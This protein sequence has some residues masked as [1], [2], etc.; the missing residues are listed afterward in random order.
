MKALLQ[1]LLKFPETGRICRIV[2]ADTVYVVLSE[3]GKD[4][5]HYSPPFKMVRTLLE[6]EIDG[7]LVEVL[8]NDPYEVEPVCLAD[9]DDMS[10]EQRAKEEKLDQRCGHA[11][12][13]VTWILTEV[14]I[15]IG[16]KKVW[17]QVTVAAA[18]RSKLMS[19]GGAA[20]HNVTTVRRWLNIYWR[21]GCTK[22]GLRADYRNIGRTKP[23]STAKKVGRK[24]LP[25]REGCKNTENDVTRMKKFIISCRG[26]NL[27]AK[28]QHNLYLMEFHRDGIDGFELD[29]TP[30]I[31]TQ[32][33]DKCP[34]LPAFIYYRYKDMDYVAESIAE[35]GETKHKVDHRPKPGSYKASV[36]APLE[37]VEIDFTVGSKWLV[38][39][40]NRKQIL[41]KPVH[42]VAY[43]VYSSA[44]LGLVGTWERA[45]E[46]TLRLLLENVM[47]DKVAFCARYGKVIKE[48]DWPMRYIPLHCVFDRGSESKW[49]IGDEFPD[50]FGFS[51]ENVATGDPGQKPSVESHFAKME[52][53]S[54]SRPGWEPRYWERGDDDAKA[55]AGL[56]LDAEMKILLEDVLHHNNSALPS[57][58]IDPDARAAGCRTPT[59]V[60]LFGMKAKA[61]KLK[62][63]RQ[64]TLRW[65][66]APP[67]K[68]MLTGDAIRYRNIEYTAPELEQWLTKVKKSHRDYIQIR[69]NPHL[70]DEIYYRPDPK[71]QKD[72]II[73]CE[74]TELFKHFKG[75]SFAEVAALQKLEKEETAMLYQKQRNKDLAHSTRTKAIVAQET[76]LTREARKADGHSP[77]DYLDNN[78]RQHRSDEALERSHESYDG[79]GLPAEN[80]ENV[81]QGEFIQ[82]KSVAA[83]SISVTPTEPG[84][85]KSK[86]GSLKRFHKLRKK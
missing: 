29:G 83:N 71:R 64:D 44:V 38:A 49:S 74:L 46:M 6:S 32:N 37:R 66:I 4:R 56:T 54:K 28:E 52:R 58:F 12:A 36:R 39:R 62:M 67:E 65:R 16:D 5:A 55:E 77:K 42:G 25:G 35:H 79:I 20:H 2:A 31:T 11:Y 22:A 30:I 48:Q 23:R 17:R 14:G 26:K 53:Q 9:R 51:W 18:K 60:F 80:P 43:D 34:S 41:G 81:I 3:I 73:T 13:V 57:R 50:E 59:E 21:N 7:H 33:H 78:M 19:A 75:S 76:K 1:L 61:G 10:E 85:G 86:N 84:P 27:T 15:D 24:A 47:S 8:D 70:V 68:A 45:S 72:L 40:S 69:R 82:N 63:A